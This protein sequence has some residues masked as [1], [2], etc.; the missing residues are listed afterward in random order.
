MF[1]EEW[2]DSIYFPEKYEI[3]SLGRLRNKENKHIFKLSNK[4]DDYFNIVLYY[5]GQRKTTSIHRLVALA[6]IPNPNNYPC[7]NHKDLNKQN[8]KIDNLEWC[9]R[10]QNVRHAIE[11]GVAMTKSLIEKNMNKSYEKYGFICQFDKNMNLLAK[12]KNFQ[13]AGKITGVCSRDI[14]AC[15][16]N[17]KHR[18][19][20]GG[21]IWKSEKKEGG[22]IC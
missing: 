15:V 20:A 2:K 7:V 9:T 18:R 3:S 14:C 16:N 4:N 19:T 17:E 8:N 12:Y 1:N 6:F 21:F 10:S 13:I 11:N 22:L 5:N